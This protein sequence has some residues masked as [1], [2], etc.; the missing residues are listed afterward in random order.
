[1]DWAKAARIL[2]SKLTLF[3]YLAQYIV[4]TKEII[5]FSAIKNS[6]LEK[7]SL[8]VGK[9]PILCSDF[10]QFW[11]KYQ[12]APIRTPKFDGNVVWDA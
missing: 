4:Y 1:M 9:K 2:G 12:N 11:K 3:A 6:K 7:T 10:G 5:I 8:K